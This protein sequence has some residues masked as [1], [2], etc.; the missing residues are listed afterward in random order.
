MASVQ[1]TNQLTTTD[2]DI[3]TPRPNDGSARTRAK[4]YLLEVEL[5]NQ[6]IS[7]DVF[8]DLSTSFDPYVQ[9]FQVPKGSRGANVADGALLLAQVDD[10]GIGVNSKIPSSGVQYSNGAGPTLT[11]L[12][13]V[14]YVVRVT[15]LDTLT[16]LPQPFTLQVS[17]PSGSV[18]LK[19]PITGANFNAG[20][21][22]GVPVAR[23]FD[24]TAGG[25]F[26]TTDRIEKSDRLTNPS[27]FQSEGDEFTAPGDGNA[28]VQRF[29]NTASG[30]Y[31]FTNKPGEIQFVRTL[32]QFRDQGEVFNSYSTAVP[33]AIPVYR[34]TNLARERENQQ[35]ITHFFTA[36]AEQ[37]RLVQAR[38]DFRDEG[39]AFYALPPA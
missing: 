27:R 28:K 3:P 22:S 32:P 23:F 13:G 29:F 14:D 38:S 15:S 19:D 4:D 2:K 18:A 11:S 30:T 16:Q 8:K 5:V 6:P 10:G 1:V 21:S 9:V 34:F 24:K 20:G 36:S 35:N 33:G 39:V 31:F 25:H 17:T 7:I 26:Y 37:R 12:P